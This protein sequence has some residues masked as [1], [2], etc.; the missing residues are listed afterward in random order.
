MGANLVELTDG[1]LFLAYS[2][3]AASTTT[4][5]ARSVEMTDGGDT[6]STPFD[7]AVPDSDTEAVRVDDQVESS[8]QQIR[9]HW[10]P[11]DS[12]P[13]EPYLLHSDTSVCAL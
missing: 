12:K 2:R 6:W 13:D 5:A 3:W 11:H 9:C 10:P 8:L 4:T 7:A 1:S